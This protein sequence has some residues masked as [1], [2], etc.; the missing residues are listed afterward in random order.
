M[1]E[2]DSRAVL[3]LLLFFGG[4]P[5]R[6]R[7]DFWPVYCNLEGEMDGSCKSPASLRAVTPVSIHDLLLFVKSLGNEGYMICRALQ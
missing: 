6:A 1:L 7:G 2:S 4:T 5:T 3:Q